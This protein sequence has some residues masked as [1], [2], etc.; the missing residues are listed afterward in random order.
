MRKEMSLLCKLS[1]IETLGSHLIFF[2]LIKLFFFF[3]LRKQLVTTLKP[4][5][6]FVLFLKYIWTNSNTNKMVVIFT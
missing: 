2:S 3:F 5:E 4:A 1:P 6:A